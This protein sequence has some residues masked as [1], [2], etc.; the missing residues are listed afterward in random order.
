MNSSKFAVVIVNYNTCAFLRACLPTVIAEQPREMIMVDNA[1]NDGSVQMVREDFPAV[2]LMPLPV[3]LGYGA[4]ANQG[5]R[6][7]DAEFVL[8]LNSDTRVH[9]GALQALEVYFEQHPGAGIVGPRLLNPDGTLQASCYPEPTP[10][11]VLLEES[12]LGRWVRYIPPMRERYLRTWS[13]SQPRVVPW[14]LGAALAIRRRAFDSVRGFD[15]SFFLYWEEVDLCYRLGRAGWEIHFA[16]GAVVTHYGGA[17]T[18]LHHLEMT[19][20]LFTSAAHFY[21]THYSRA[22]LFA[23]RVFI[24]LIM[25]A[26]MGRDFAHLALYVVRNQRYGA[27]PQALYPNLHADYQILTDALAGWQAA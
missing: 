14:V 1:S 20:R 13:H 26:R 19:R 16:P 17:S 8:L 21:R 10:L 4:A 11:H 3:N 24:I 6:A 23:L 7:C 25:L 9:G 27:S 18:R 15:E 2:T 22:R 5:I 12:T